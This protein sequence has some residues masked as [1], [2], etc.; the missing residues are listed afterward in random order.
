MNETKREMEI[1]RLEQQIEELQ[2]K[3]EMLRKERKRIP[4][5]EK[6][7]QAARQAVNS[8]MTNPMARIAIINSKIKQE[9]N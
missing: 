4:L 8:A 5:K 6:M 2:Q 3:L 9:E 1:R 7:A